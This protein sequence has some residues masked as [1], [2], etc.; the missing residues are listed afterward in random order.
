MINDKTFFVEDDTFYGIKLIDKTFNDCFFKGVNFYNA[1]LLMCQF[2]NC[3]FESCNFFDAM[4]RQSNFVTSTFK[5]CI[6]WHSANLEFAKFNQSFKD[7]LI[8]LVFKK[9]IFD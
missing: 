7:E 8:T 2:N 4:F 6:G 9:V 5:S 1:Q 3:T